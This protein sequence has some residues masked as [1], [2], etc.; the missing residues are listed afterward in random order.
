MSVS[1]LFLWFVCALPWCCNDC[2]LSSGIVLLQ[3]FFKFP[4][5]EWL[6][7]C[8]LVARGPVLGF[9]TPKGCTMWVSRAAKLCI[10][11]RQSASAKYR[12]WRMQSMDQSAQYHGEISW[13]SI[14]CSHFISWHNFNS[15]QYVQNQ[16]HFQTHDQNKIKNS[17]LKLQITQYYTAQKN[18]GNTKITHPRSE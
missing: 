12:S 16:I 4:R 3:G 13:R 18:K 15:V 7:C 10:K 9:H 17:A 2:F 11:S 14:D 8:W 5:T 6:C 1:T